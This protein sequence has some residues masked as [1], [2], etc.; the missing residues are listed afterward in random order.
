M[1]ETNVKVMPGCHSPVPDVRDEL[2]ESLEELLD[3]ARDGRLQ[4]F[5]GVGLATDET[6][7]T[8]YYPGKKRFTEAGA[9]Q[10]MVHRYLSNECE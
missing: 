1:A 4:S 9:L 10:T 3:E 2:V 7:K 6:I 8:M 5:V